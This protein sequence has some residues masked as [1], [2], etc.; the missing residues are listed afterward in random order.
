MPHRTNDLCCALRMPACRAACCLQILHLLPPASDVGVGEV[1]V[2][3]FNL[4]C[5]CWS[6][7]SC[8]CCHRVTGSD[9]LSCCCA[10]SSVTCCR[11]SIVVVSCRSFYRHL[12]CCT[13]CMLVSTPVHDSL[14][15]GAVVTMA[16]RYLLH[17]DGEHLVHRI[18]KAYTENW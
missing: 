17:S 8:S 10:C 14:H 13:R 11:W 12:R 2:I 1:V 15:A 16:S 7:G 3:F 5:F 9:L 6:T 18:L 4:F